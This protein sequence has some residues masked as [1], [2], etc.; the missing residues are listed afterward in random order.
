MRSL[1]T[2]WQS[3]VC[4]RCGLEETREE[5]KKC[6][7]Q[8]FSDCTERWYH[9]AVDYTVANGLMG[10]TGKRRFAPYDTMTR[11]MMVT[12]LYRAVGEP[13]I[14][15]PSTFS[16]VPTGQWYSDAIAWA[17]VNGVV[18][19]V[20]PTTFAPDSPV[21][22]EQIAVIL[23]RYAKAEVVKESSSSAFPDAD[24]VSGYAV[25]AMNWAVAEGLIAGSEGKL[26]PQDSATRAEI[27]IILM[28]L[29]EK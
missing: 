22:R 24:K 2:Q 9:E 8:S 3:R 23:F 17:A 28:R 11:A 29:L 21:T 14:A 15:E 12:V 4:S 1:I 7:V 26:L 16:D 5:Q 20:T 27:A 6:Y 19:G 25:D 10:G 18:N 13:P